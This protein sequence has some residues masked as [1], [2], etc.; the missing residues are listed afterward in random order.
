MNNQQSDILECLIDKLN[1]FYKSKTFAFKRIEKKVESKNNTNINIYTIMIQKVN[2]K[3]KISLLKKLHCVR[4][5]DEDEKNVK[6]EITLSDN[7]NYHTAFDN[8]VK[9]IDSDKTDIMWELY[10]SV[11]PEIKKD[12]NFYYYHKKDYTLS[13]D[14][15]FNFNSSKYKYFKNIIKNDKVY[16]EEEKELFNYMLEFC[17]KAH[18]EPYNASPIIEIGGLNQFKQAIGNDRQDIFLNEIEYYFKENKLRILENGASPQMSINNRDIL[19]KALDYFGESDNGY[20]NFLMFFYHLSTLDEYYLK[21]IMLSGKKRIN[22]CR[23]LYRYMNLAIQYWIK[24]SNIYCSSEK[25]QNI[26]LKTGALP[27]D[28][29]QNYLDHYTSMIDPLLNKIRLVQRK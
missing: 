4:I 11:N 6:L 10:T 12:K 3:R 22:D 23:S 29:L 2:Q 24:L 28:I 25:S 19:E 26:Y 15:I 14:R 18:E 16:T 20:K 7:Y 5:L 27:P 8:I 21:E 13:G 9:T 17:H 1:S